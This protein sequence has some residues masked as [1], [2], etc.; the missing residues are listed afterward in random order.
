MLYHFAYAFEYKNFY[1]SLANE[2]IN[3]DE[4]NLE[5]LRQMAKMTLKQS[6]EV[7]NILVNFRYDD[8][9]LENPDND[10][11]QAYLWHIVVVASR[12]VEAPSLSNNRFH[13]SHYVMEH[14]LRFVGWDTVAYRSLVFGKP[15]TSLTT[16]QSIETVLAQIGTYG[17]F[18]KLEDI[19]ELKA[20]LEE[21]TQQ[22]MKP[23]LEDFPR[24]LTEYAQH[25]SLS[26]F[27]MLSR[28][29]KDAIDMLTFAEQRQEALYLFRD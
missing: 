16:S 12:F 19:I 26:I 8:E 24:I 21:N 1:T 20:K 7:R 10:F 5:A 4:I 11:S 28:A 9:W 25:N 18:L 6:P 22:F 23:R 17:G 14:F 15:I 13:G 29:Y 3:G 27:E 2:L